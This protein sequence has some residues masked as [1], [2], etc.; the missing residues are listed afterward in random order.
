MIDIFDKHLGAHYLLYRH[1]RRQEH[2][3]DAGSAFAQ[4]IQDFNGHAVRDLI[5]QL[6]RLKVSTGTTV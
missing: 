5:R 6:I 2:M 4:S 1:P 3:Y